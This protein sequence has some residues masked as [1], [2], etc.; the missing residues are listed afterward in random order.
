MDTVRRSLTELRSATA[1]LSEAAAVADPMEPRQV[2]AEIEL[3]LKELSI[4]C[5]T[6]GTPLTD[7]RGRAPRERADQLSRQDRRS[8]L[9]ALHVIGAAVGS[10]ARACRTERRALAAPIDESVSLV[11]R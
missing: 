2:I 1:R 10:A 8:T 3:V 6:L 9:A 5:Y 4:T 7:E 11:L